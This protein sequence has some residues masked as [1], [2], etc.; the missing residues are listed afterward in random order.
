MDQKELSS[1]YKAKHDVLEAAF[2]ETGDL[3]TRKLREGRSIEVF[4]RIHREQAADYEAAMIEAGFSAEL[5]LE[6]HRVT[7]F[8]KLLTYMLKQ[9]LLAPADITDILK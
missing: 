2:F 6:N 3:G 4:D 9:R 5:L 1:T 7:P 8:E